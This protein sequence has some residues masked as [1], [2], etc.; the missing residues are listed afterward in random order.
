MTE[1]EL[2]RSRRKTLSVQVTRECRAIVRAPPRL[3]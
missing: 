2:V 3:A 1:Y